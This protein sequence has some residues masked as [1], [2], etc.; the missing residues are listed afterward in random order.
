MSSAW[1][2]RRAIANLEQAQREL[3][4]AIERGRSLLVAYPDGPINE[5]LRNYF[6]GLELQLR[7]IE[8]K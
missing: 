8:P 1:T 2:S 6:K 5:T 7:A 3:Q 4:H